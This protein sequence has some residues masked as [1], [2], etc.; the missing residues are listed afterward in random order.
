MS[1]IGMP[2]ITPL[3]EAAKDMPAIPTAE[4]ALPKGPPFEARFARAIASLLLR[5]T[6]CLAILAR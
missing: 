4:A 6:P 3:A 5:P 2:A 1:T